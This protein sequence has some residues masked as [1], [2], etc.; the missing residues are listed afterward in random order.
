MRRNL[1]TKWLLGRTLCRKLAP[2]NI[3][4]H[5]SHFILLET[6]QNTGQNTWQAGRKGPLHTGSRPWKHK[7][8]YIY[9]YISLEVHV[10]A[11]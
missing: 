2:P 10:L 3:H 7:Y 11:L 9:I 6:I 4:A 1:S 5:I 8:I